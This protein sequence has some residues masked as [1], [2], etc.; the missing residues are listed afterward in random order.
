MTSDTSTNVYRGF[1]IPL[2]KT[3]S[4]LNIWPF[5]IPYMTSKTL[6]RSHKIQ[7]N[8]IELI[9]YFSS[10]S[11]SYPI[12]DEVMSYLICSRTIQRF[13]TS[14]AYLQNSSC[15]FFLF[16]ENF[17]MTKYAD[18][19]KYTFMKINNV[20]CHQNV[21]KFVSSLALVVQSNLNLYRS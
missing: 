21:Q 14:I 13:S 9:F 15:S 6:S 10:L 17:P 19:W 16:F 4:R 20:C 3:L 5:H 2:Y 1:P 8:H 11:Q 18:F 7:D 12:K